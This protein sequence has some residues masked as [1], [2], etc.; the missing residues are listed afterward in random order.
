MNPDAVDNGPYTGMKPENGFDPNVVIKEEKHKPEYD[1]YMHQPEEGEG[2]G[3]PAPPPPQEQQPPEETN[4][5]G[6][7]QEQTE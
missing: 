5:Y 4:E 3:Q 2:D 6:S 7:V 1:K